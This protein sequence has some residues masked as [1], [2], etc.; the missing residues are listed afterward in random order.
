[1]VSVVIPT[2]NAGNYLPRL[3]DALAKQ[4][5]AHELIIVDST[6]RDNTQAILRERNIPFHE[7]SPA[8]F[9]HGGTRNLAMSFTSHPVVIMM[10]QDALPVHPDTLKNLVAMLLRDEN[11]GMAYGRQLPYPEAG[12]LSQFARMTNYP[13]ESRLKAWKDIPSLGIRTCHC[14]NSFAA[15]KKADFLAVGGFPTDTIL[16][17]DVVLAAK[18]ITNGKSLA[19]CAEA[20]VYHSHD[21]ALTE[22]FR[23]YFD[24]GAF[25]QQQEKLLQPFTGAESEGLKYVIQEWK[26]L[27]GNNHLALIPAQVL[28]TAAKLVGYKL[29]KWQRHLPLS[30]KQKISMHASFWKN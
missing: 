29:G 16:G 27:A 1:M 6:S 17:E 13:A 3:L 11:I 4:T 10:T 28:R 18:L 22:E 19:Y 14:S 5:L 30:L 15:Y 21:Y 7:V 2:Y 12:I 23:R 24:I 9:N 8:L 20:P 26:Y 25:H